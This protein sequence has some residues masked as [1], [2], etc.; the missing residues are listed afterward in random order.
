MRTLTHL[1]LRRQRLLKVVRRQS[2]K[3]RR[4]RLYRFDVGAEAA[5]TGAIVIDVEHLQNIA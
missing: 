1:V 4:R 2:L 5:R 3:Q